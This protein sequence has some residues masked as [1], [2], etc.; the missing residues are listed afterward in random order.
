MPKLMSVWYIW[1]G[2][3]KRMSDECFV[4]MKF[5]ILWETPCSC[6]PSCLFTPRSRFPLFLQSAP[7][8]T[9][10]NGTRG[11]R[12]SVCFQ[13][14]KHRFLKLELRIFEFPNP[15]TSVF[16]LV[17][18]FSICNGNLCLRTVR[19]LIRLTGSRSQEL[20][21]LLLRGVWCFGWITTQGKSYLQA[22]LHWERGPAP[23]NELF[24]TSWLRL[25]SS[26]HF[27]MCIRVWRR[28]K[29]RVREEDAVTTLQRAWMRK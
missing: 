29:C 18:S 14:F 7:C 10:T 8:L 13:T 27:R 3:I 21:L 22:C 28:E 9:I 15:Q 2:K 4:P 5:L 16:P 17:N 26:F 25:F 11:R 20:G 12:V 23:F 24:Y 1:M 6:C 19:S